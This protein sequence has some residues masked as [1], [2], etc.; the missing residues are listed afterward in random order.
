M[1]LKAAK[2]H[3][4]VGEIDLKIDCM[5]RVFKII[6]NIKRYTPEEDCTNTTCTIKDGS[7]LGISYIDI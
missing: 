6:N 1:S 5:L 4:T 2:K 3:S 7:K